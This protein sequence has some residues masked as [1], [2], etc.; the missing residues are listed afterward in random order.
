MGADIDIKEVFN[1]YWDR[2]QGAKLKLPKAMDASFANPQTNE[3]K[4]IY[5][6]IKEFNKTEAAKLEQEVFKQRKRLA[7]TQ[8]SLQTKITKKALEDN[9]SRLTRL[10]G[11]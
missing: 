5:E 6:L 2:T 9:A 8:R 7:N 1:V 3:Q 10:H 11:V 4:A